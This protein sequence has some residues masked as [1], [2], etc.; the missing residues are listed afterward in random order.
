MR[1]RVPWVAAGQRSG[2]G[3][4]GRQD[5]R[6]RQGGDGG[7]HGG[8]PGDGGCHRSGQL[9]VSCRR[10]SWAGGRRTLDA[11]PRQELAVYPLQSRTRSLSRP[12]LFGRASSSSSP[13]RV[14]VRWISAALAGLCLCQIRPACG[15]VL[16]R[17]PTPSHVSAPAP[18]FLAGLLSAASPAHPLVSESRV[19]P[20][21]P[22]ETLMPPRPIFPVLLLR[23]SAPEEL[24]LSSRRSSRRGAGIR[25]P[26][27][28]GS[29]TP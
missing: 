13:W 14:F 17:E 9:W 6:L 25:P 28:R 7:H 12:P 18:L 19:A 15:M 2:G 4:E 21:P 8:A 1:C 3:R 22:E 23:G 24:V 10:L 11:F 20:F 16:A 27:C 29:G 5:R 26:P